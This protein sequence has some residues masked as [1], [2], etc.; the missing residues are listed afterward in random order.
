[1]LRIGGCSKLLILEANTGLLLSKAAQACALA[2]GTNVD[3]AGR[4]KLRLLYIRGDAEV[5]VGSASNQ[6]ESSLGLVSNQADGWI[7][8]ADCSLLGG[9]VAAAAAAIRE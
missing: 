1:M 3:H 4:Q 5:R 2:V 7:L 6:Y 9:A 8:L